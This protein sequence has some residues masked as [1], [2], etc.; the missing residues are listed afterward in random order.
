MAPAKP[1]H[2]T[3][4][5]PEKRVRRPVIL[6]PVKPLPPHPADS[7]SEGRLRRSFRRRRFRLT[8][9]G[10]ALAALLV[11]GT[12]F[13]IG[14]AMYLRGS[15]IVTVRPETLL[16]YRDAGPDGAELWLAVPIQ[17]INAA[18]TDYGDVVTRA[19]LRLNG[20]AGHFD[21]ETLVEPVFVPAPD[22]NAMARRVERA[23]DNCPTGARC[24]AGIGHY[25]IE[26]PKRLLDIPGGSS[27]SEYLGFQLS[28]Y[29]CRPGGSDCTGFRGFQP[30]VANLRRQATLTAAV[31]LQFQFDE[32]QEVRC[33]VST[34]H[35]TWSSLL[36]Y[37]ERTGWVVAECVNSED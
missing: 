33:T 31:T 18:S 10:V 28:A 29:S 3:G 19:T 15:E 7:A 27:R 32:P 2:K 26:R 34:R 22:R 21:Y 24:I 36:A 16:L 35:A 37:L 25:V 23:I 5:S 13:L 11:S 4:G 8:E 6:R 14:G 1:P 30:T 9:V 20:G 12:A 17:L